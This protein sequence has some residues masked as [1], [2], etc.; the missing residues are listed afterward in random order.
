MLYV[1]T[2]RLTVGATPP[3]LLGVILKGTIAGSWINVEASVK[4]CLHLGV[5]RAGALLTAI[6]TT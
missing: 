3:P 4:R 5:E 2:G 1:D 6:G